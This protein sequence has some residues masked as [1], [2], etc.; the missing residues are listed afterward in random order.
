VKQPFSL[1]HRPF[2][3]I[4]IKGLDT[5]F[6]LSANKIAGKNRN[7]NDYRAIRY[8]RKRKNLNKNRELQNKYF[9]QSMNECA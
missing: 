1:S 8:S 2:L 5:E 9:I 4:G 7:R 3:I 6:M